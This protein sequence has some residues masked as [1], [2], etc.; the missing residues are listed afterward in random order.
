MDRNFFK[1]QVNLDREKMN[2]KEKEMKEERARER[3]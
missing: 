1:K 2:E 3:E